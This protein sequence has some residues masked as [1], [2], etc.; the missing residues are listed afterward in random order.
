MME[1]REKVKTVKDKNVSHFPSLFLFFFFSLL[2][3]S[4]PS[5][6]HRHRHRHRSPFFVEV[7]ISYGYRVL[8]WS[9]VFSLD[10][11]IPK[12]GDKGKLFGLLTNESE[13]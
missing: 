11:S 8:P 13:E 6:Q 9:P 10:E 12:N 7:L 5:H 2:V 1:H 4:S 3:S